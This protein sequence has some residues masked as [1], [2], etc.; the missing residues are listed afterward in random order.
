[1]TENKRGYIMGKRERD[2]RAG[3]ALCALAK[4]AKFRRR[5][6]EYGSVPKL[7]SNQSRD[8]GCGEF[9]GLIAWYHYGAGEVERSPLC[10]ALDDTWTTCVV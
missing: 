7:L 5:W 8:T 10:L 4:A 2:E 9:L 1:M 3:S 6:K